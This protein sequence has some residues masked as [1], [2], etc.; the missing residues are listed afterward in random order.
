MFMIVHDSI[1]S[2][3]A[4]WFNIP[5]ERFDAIHY[6]LIG[7]YELAIFVVLLGP[8]FALCIVGAG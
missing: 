5:A 3:H 8:Y 4:E 2:V 1:Q 6:T 7:F